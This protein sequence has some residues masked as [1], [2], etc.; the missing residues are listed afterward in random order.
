MMAYGKTP[1]NEDISSKIVEILTE[2]LQHIQ[3][4]L[5]LS[6]ISGREHYLFSLRHIIIAIQSLRNVDE[7]ARNQIT[8]VAPFL[9]HELFRIINDQLV[10]EIDQYW[11]NDTINEIFRNVK[12]NFLLCRQ[13]NV[14]FDLTFF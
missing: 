12:K 14:H 9:K 2:T 3:R 5:L 13:K 4:V 11:F 8:F 7:Q 10:R 6:P 1:I